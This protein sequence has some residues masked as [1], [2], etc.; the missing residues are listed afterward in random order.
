MA[1]PKKGRPKK[2]DAKSSSD[3]LPLRDA[4][5]QKLAGSQGLPSGPPGQTP[6][7]LI[8]ELQ[9]HQIELEMQADELK[10]IQQSLEISRCK[11]MDLYDFAPVGYLTLSKNA[12]IE[13]GNLTGA[14][15]FGLDRRNLIK[16]RFRKF[17]AADDRERWDQHFVS[18]LHSEEKLNCELKLTKND[19]SLFHARVESIRMARENEDPMIRIA[20]SDISDRKRDEEEIKRLSEER[21]TLIDNVPAMIWYKDTKNTIIRVNPAGARIFGMPASAVEGKSVYDLFREE[22]ADYYRDDLEV[23]RSG[24]PKFG[25]VHQMPVA[26]GGKLWVRTDKIPLRDEQGTITGLLVFNVDITE[27]KQAEDQLIRKSDDVNATNRELTESLREKESLLA[28]IHHRVKNNLQIISGLLDMMR[29]RT[30]DPATTGLLTDMMLKI[31]TMSQIHETL[32]K[33]HRFSSVDMS[34]YL[35][36]L[37]EQVAETYHSEEAILTVVNAEGIGLDLA[38]ATPCGLIVNELL[39]NSFRYAFPASFECEA[40]RHEMCTIRVSFTLA[41]GYYTLT[42]RDNGVGLPKGF[43]ATKAK[44]LGLDLV[45][46]IAN[47]Q[48]RAEI[49]V[50]AENGTEFAIRFKE[51]VPVS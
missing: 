11:Y 4:A 31:T 15:L 33:T 26:E 50:T 9:V 41:D 44:S 40:I 38:R 2:K 1:V 32:Y 12:V 28:E 45:N 13:E 34:E 22:A 18:V 10:R 36:R 20:I 5:E 39:T 14:A 16:D 21:K 24:R 7:E 46:F 6:E 30:H 25:I 23:I 51:K 3:N 43:D 8:H 29:M 37:T 35:T 42:V 17:V 49:R 48:L 27:I 19:G 47:H